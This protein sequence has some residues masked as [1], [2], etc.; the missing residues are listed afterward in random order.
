MGAGG[1]TNWGLRL[2][3]TGAGGLEVAT[4]QA[5]GDVSERCAPKA[6]GLLD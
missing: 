5:G 3:G 4:R 2:S 1:G 6:L